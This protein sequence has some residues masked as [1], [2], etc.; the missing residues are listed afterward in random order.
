MAES[1]V[2]LW[3]NSQWGWITNSG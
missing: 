1:V 3:L 2:F